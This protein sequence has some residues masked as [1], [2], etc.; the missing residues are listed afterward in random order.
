[1]GETEQELQL[2]SPK[3]IYIDS[4]RERISAGAFSNTTG[5]DEMS[6][7]WAL[8]SPAAES[9]ARWSK[10]VAIGRFSKQVCDDLGQRCEHQPLAENPAHRGVIGLTHRE[11]LQSGEP[12]ETMLDT[13]IVGSLPKPVWLAEPNALFAPWRLEGERLR[14]GQDDAVRLALAD[15]ETA[16]LDIVTDGEQRRCHYIWGFLAGLTGIDM[17]RPGT[18]LARGGRY[19]QQTSVARIVNDITRPAPVLLDAVCFARAHTT[20]KL[21]VTLPGPMTT[22]DSLLDEHYHTDEQTL[23][24]RFATILNQ[25][26]AQLAEA[27]ADIIQF[28]EP[29]F[30]IYT[31]RVGEWGIE[32]L[33]RCI[34]GVAA[35]TAVHVCYGYGVPAVLAWK[36]RNR[37]WGHYAVTLPLLAKSHID[38]VSVE[39]AASGVDVSVLAALAGKDVMV[40]VIDVGAETVETPE[41][42]AARIHRALLYVPA[43]RLFPCTD[44][45]LVPRS[46]DAAR[47]KLRALAAG[48]A[49]VRGE[50]ANSARAIVT[51]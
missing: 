44:C 40:G 23:A 32:A 5:T 43:E 37:D 20:R 49:I 35:R 29:C 36:T 6:V 39:C 11:A 19:S 25:E 7:D 27:G 17:E 34:D 4:K 24:M 13:M 10:P 30:N 48:A 14:E 33:E 50:L 47:G 26:A 45:G 12:E 21:K 31:D 15:Q 2:R 18:K 9:M 41:V 51:R 3:R 42:V 46:R 1:M 16:G 8:L 22:V 28:D 38:Q